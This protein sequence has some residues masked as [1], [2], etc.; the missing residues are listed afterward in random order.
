[1]TDFTHPIDLDQVRR[2]AGILDGWAVRTPLLRSRELDSLTGAN[3]VLKPEN[4]QRTGSFKFRGGFTAVSSLTPE[5]QRRGVV[6][7]SSGNHAQAIALAARLRRIDATIVMPADA[8]AMKL[9]ATRGYGAEVVTYDRATGDREAIARTIAEERGRTVIPPYDHPAVMAGQGTTALELVEDGG[10]LTMLIAPVGG[11]GLMAGCAT[12]AKAL[13][14]GIRVI[15][16]EPA[17]GDDTRRSLAAGEPVAVPLP[18]TIADGLQAPHPGELTFAI[19]RRLVD[20]I[21]VVSD[22]EIVAAMRLLFEA[23]KVVAEP[24][25]AVALAALVSGRIDVAD[26]RVGVIISGGNVSAERFAQ[27]NAD[28]SL[29]S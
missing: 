6:A 27:L 14:P 21:E 10:E 12:A 7:F 3:V 5:L 1:M 16:V 25:G 19:N 2:A 4:L 13:L 17:A 29:S 20:A 28:A 22:A 24:S 15:G 11:G 26:H 9:D 8:P 23:F 18:D